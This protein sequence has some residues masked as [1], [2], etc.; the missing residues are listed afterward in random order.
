MPSEIREKIAETE[1][2]LAKTSLS[3]QRRKS[4]GKYKKRLQQ[5]L[6][7]YEMYQGGS[8]GSKVL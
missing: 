3:S 5:S 2:E 7:L 8:C 4:L 1:R 6:R